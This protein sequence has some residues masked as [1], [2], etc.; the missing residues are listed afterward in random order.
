V[1][2]ELGL[3]HGLAKLLEGDGQPFPRLTRPL[4][5]ELGELSL[6]QL[7]RACVRLRLCLVE[8]RVPRVLQPAIS[9]MRRRRWRPARAR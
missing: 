9:I 7:L 2:A 5:P 3:R 8:L 6:S 1:L 4:R